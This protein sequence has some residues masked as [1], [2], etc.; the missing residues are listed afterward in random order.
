MIVWN[1]AF[2]SG[3]AEICGRQPLKN[4]KW[5]GLL[6]QTILLTSNFLKGCLP[7]NILSPLLNN[8]SHKLIFHWI[9]ILIVFSYDFFTKLWLHEKILTNIEFGRLFCYS[10][11]LKTG[12]HFFLLKGRISSRVRIVGHG[13]ARFRWWARGFSSIF[14]IQILRFLFPIDTGYRV[15]N[16]LNARCCS[17]HYCMTVVLENTFKYFWSFACY[18]YDKGR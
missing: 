11:V 17:F 13:L 7:E 5:Y 3:P 12:L 15:V 16:R 14:I 2:K 18:L 9:F 8:L 4:L 6:K 1:K 10:Y